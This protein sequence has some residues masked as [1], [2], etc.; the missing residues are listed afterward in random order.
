MCDRVH[1]LRTFDLKGSKYNRETLA[2]KSV[3]DLSTVTLKDI[4]FLKTED[5]IFVSPI[6]A[7]NIKRILCS[8]IQM[9]KSLGV[10]D[11]SLLIM[12]INWDQAAFFNKSSIREVIP[13][14]SNPFEVVPSEVEE[15]VYYHFTIIDYLQT[16]NVFR[17]T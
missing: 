5:R 3:D 14:G 2:E 12:K 9:L 8:D 13:R 16:W 4:D 17:Q 10:M 7:K 11:Y 6:T 15:G 1:I